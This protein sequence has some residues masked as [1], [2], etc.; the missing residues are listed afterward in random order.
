MYRQPQ[1][2]LNFGN[3]FLQGLLTYFKPC[4]VNFPKIKTKLLYGKDRKN[5]SEIRELVV[6]LIVTFEHLFDGSQIIN[7][8][9]SQKRIIWYFR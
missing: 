8:L 6:L 7:D 4:S 2:C 5:F 3:L 1:N 9:E